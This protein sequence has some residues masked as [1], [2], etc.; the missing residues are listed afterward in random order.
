MH[1]VYKVDSQTGMITN[2]KVY[3]PNPKNPT[4]FDEILGYDAIGKSHKNKVTGE[5]L[6]PHIHDRNYPGGVQKPNPDE[7]P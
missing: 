3:T 4:G 2:Y 5:D 6:M 1:V 7:I